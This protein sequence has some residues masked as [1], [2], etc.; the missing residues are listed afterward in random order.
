MPAIAGPQAWTDW[1]KQ[2]ESADILATANSYRA[3]LTRNGTAE[4]TGPC[5]VC[6][7]TDRFSINIKKKLWNCRGCGKGGNV[8][9]LVAWI[10]ASSYIE[11]CE[12]INGTPRP[13]RTR[14]ETLEQRNS[15]LAE[16]ARLRGIELQRREAEQQA[17]EAAK[18]KR[19]EEMI[20][21]VINRAIPILDS[22]HGA[23]YLRGRGLN[24][25]A[26]LIKDLRFVPDLDYWGARDNGTREIVLLATLPAVVAIIRDFAGLPI[27]L[28]Q[29]YLDPVEPR[30]W[31]PIGSPSNS[32]TKIRG[33]KKHGRVALGPNADI[34]AL[35]EGWANALAW[36]QLGHGPDNVALAAAVDIGNMAGGATGW[37]PHPYLRDVDGKPVRMKN[38]VPDMTKP[39]IILPPEAGIKSIILLADLDSE[40]YATAA[41]LRTAGNR[42]RTMGLHVDVAWPSGRG[43]DWNDILAATAQTGDAHASV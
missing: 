41:Q 27:G 22:E 28:S 29:T 42:F 18:A 32:A 34:L 6:G 21:K 37:V 11:A 43:K 31:T 4:W 20:N 25:H 40:T 1:I 33:E 8:V 14:D 35:S 39:G 17:E 24:P 12:K 30:K 3:R 19:D 5:I 26:R 23:A 10:T 2:A 38:G 36:H 9:H 16:N 7:G 13:D 15:R